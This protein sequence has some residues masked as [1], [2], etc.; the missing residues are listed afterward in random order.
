V[1]FRNNL[2]VAGNFQ[3]FRQ[4]QFCESARKPLVLEEVCRWWQ[5]NVVMNSICPAQEEERPK[6]NISISRHYHYLCI[7]VKMN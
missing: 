5:N 4:R 7:N 3:G 6:S 2:K 1:E